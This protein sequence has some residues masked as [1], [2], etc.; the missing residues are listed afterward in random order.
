MSDFRPRLRSAFPTILLC[1][2]GSVLGACDESITLENAAP[3]LT[4]VVVIPDELRATA[5]LSFWVSDSEGD[6]VDITARWM[7]A[8]GASGDVRQAMPAFPWSGRVTR[9]ALL[10]PNG[11]EQRFIWDLQGLPAGELQ[12]AFDVDDDPDDDRPADRWLSPRFDPRV[13]IDPAGAW[14]IVGAD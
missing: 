3:R 13:G 8:G 10:D 4:W 1:L 11:Q 14:E 2:G 5:T 12:L 6:S 9:D 7:A